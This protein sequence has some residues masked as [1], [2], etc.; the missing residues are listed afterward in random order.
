MNGTLRRSEVL[1]SATLL[2]YKHFLATVESV[3]VEL[4]R[5]RH[6]LIWKASGSVVTWG[7]SEFGGDSSSVASQL[8]SG[9]T[10]VCATYA[11]FAATKA[12]C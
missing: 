12:G 10:H 6:M 4:Q 11:A 3:S 5:K 7:D 2:I 8:R 9:I 1:D